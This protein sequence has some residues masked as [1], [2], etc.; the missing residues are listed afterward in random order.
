METTS[1]LQKMLFSG[2]YSKSQLKTWLPG[3]SPVASFSCS[4]VHR[5]AWPAARNK[6]SGGPRSGGLV[7]QEQTTERRYPRQDF[8]S[9]W[10][11]DSKIARENNF[12]KVAITPLRMSAAHVVPRERWDAIPSVLEIV[13]ITAM[14]LVSFLEVI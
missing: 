10:R 8:D 11:E 6:L 1:G 7:Q 9:C 14:Y 12:N 3:F 4:A 2:N 13:L 5:P